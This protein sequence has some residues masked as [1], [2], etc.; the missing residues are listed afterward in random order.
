M[1]ARKEAR[2]RA[3]AWKKEVAKAAKCVASLTAVNQALQVMKPR[4]DKN[5]PFISDDMTQSLE[6]AIQN[7]QS[8]KQRASVSAY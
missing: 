8:L 4:V 6:T 7:V 1:A 3:A 2:E 5:L